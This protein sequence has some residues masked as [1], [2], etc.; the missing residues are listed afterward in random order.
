[1]SSSSQL[2]NLQ[3]VSKVLVETD[4]FAC[5]R[6]MVARLMDEAGDMRRSGSA[7]LDLCRVAEGAYGGYIEPGLN[8]YDIAAGV[9]VVREAGGR[10]SGFPGEGSALQTGNV[11]ASNGLLHRAIESIVADSFGRNRDE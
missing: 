9:L 8:L 11:L 5:I 7:A 2:K 4:S 6:R 3:S 1:M 10:V